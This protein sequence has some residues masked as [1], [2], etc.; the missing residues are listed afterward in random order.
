MIAVCRFTHGAVVIADSRATWKQG[1]SNSYQ[2]TLQKIVPLG[3]KIAFSFAGDV[4]AAA[5]L[6]SQLRR[7]INKQPRL[8]ALHKLSAEIPRIAKHYFQVC[9]SKSRSREPLQCVLAGVDATGNIGIWCY[10]S[11]L[12]QSRELTSNYDV[13]GSGAI[14]KSY[15]HDHWETLDSGFNTLKERVD[16]LLLGLEEELV[17]RGIETVG[18]MLQV[19]L[20][21]SRGIRP[22]RRGFIT[23]DPTAAGHAKSIEMKAGKWIQRDEA[24]GI[25]VPL[26]DP[27]GL[28]RRSPQSLRFHDFKSHTIHDSKQAWYRTYFLTSLA[29][30][31]EIGTLEFKGM[32]S[33]CAATHYPMKLPIT[34]AVGLWGSA[35][36]HTLEFRLIGDMESYKLHSSSIHVEF[37]P[38]ELDLAIPVV[39][40]IRKPGPAFLECYVA[41]QLIGR[42]ALYFG[43][44]LQ[45]SDTAIGLA[46]FADQMTKQVLAEQRACSDPVLE[47]SKSELVYFSICQ[48][49]TLEGDYLKLERE[50]TAI[51]ANHYPLR[52]RLFVASAFR[53]PLGKHEIR[54]DLVNA[55]TREVSSLAKTTIDSDSSCIVSPIH[56]EL[57]G[58][59]PKAGLYFV[60]AYVDGQL[61]G[62][63]VLAAET[64]QAQYSYRLLNEDAEHVAAGGT[65]VL[66]KG[67]QLRATTN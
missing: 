40:D 3:P 1:G 27:V 55:A 53:S 34:A 37:F 39:L 48:G 42:R 15:I 47:A 18:G 35:G 65:F 29:V 23:L 13:L 16:R 6:I 60:N 7:R 11:P 12:F 64:E 14:V 56:G 50:F 61:V 66:L 28:I 67:A 59:L 52:F 26:I 63:K 38:E 22:L 36:S 8:R 17:K 21:E 9:Q 41:D 2:D 19:V 24:A 31:R 51:Y 5:I 43:E 46:N 44:A 25:E 45:P 58:T 10:Q 33:A 4:T 32:I 62:S 57:I 49:C 30:H 20:I 54:I